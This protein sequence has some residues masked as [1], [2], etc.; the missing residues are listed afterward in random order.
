MERLAV[1][2]VVGCNLE[3]S[4]P[5]TR[6][7]IAVDDQA[8]W[9]TEVRQSAEDAG[10]ALVI[11]ARVDPHVR[12]V[13]PGEARLERSL[14]RARAYLVAGADCV[15]PI[16]LAGEADIEAYAQGAPGPLTPWSPTQR[17]VRDASVNSALRASPS[18]V[19]CSA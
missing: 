5:R 7:M 8:R 4:D 16:M 10:T 13:G 6:E 15:F 12:K 17:R 18:G 11:N 3:D 14:E 1:A 2:G 19:A 9:I